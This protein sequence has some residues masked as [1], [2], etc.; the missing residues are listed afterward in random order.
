[1]M[2]KDVIKNYSLLFKCRLCG[3]IF[4][5]EKNVSEFEA[6]IIL[7]RGN[8][9]SDHK[10]NE[11]D[12]GVGEFVGVRN[13]ESILPDSEIYYIALNQMPENC[14]CSQGKYWSIEGARNPYTNFLHKAKLFTVEELRWQ[15]FTTKFKQVKLYLISEEIFSGGSH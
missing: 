14:I 8:L 6:K 4:S 3:T 5:S 11:N 12:I 15:D 9:S 7:S 1:M 2:R 13:C 10:C